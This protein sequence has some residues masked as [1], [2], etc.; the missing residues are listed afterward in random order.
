MRNAGSISYPTDL[1]KNRL[2]R[3]GCNGAAT[4][5]LEVQRALLEECRKSV[6]F[7]VNTFAWT[8]NVMHRADDPVV[9]FVTF[10][11]QDELLEEIEYCIEHKKHLVICK[12]RDVG[13]TWL[14]LALYFWR[15][16]FR[17]NQTFMVASRTEELVDGKQD[18][19]DT[20]FYRLEFFYEYTPF[21][22][23]PEG[24]LYRC[25]KGSLV[26]KRDRNVI[27][28]T[29]HSAELGRGGKRTSMM[30]DE[31]AAYTMRQG[32]RALDASQFGARSR[33][34]NST[35]EPGPNAFNTIMKRPAYRQ[36]R[37]WWTDWPEKAAGLYKT[38]VDGELVI[39]D[40]K[41][42]FPADYPFVLDGRL[43]SPYFDEQAALAS[44]LEAI[45]KELGGDVSTSSHLIFPVALLDTAERACIEAPVHVGNLEFED[46]DT[47]E[48]KKWDKREDGIVRLWLPLENGRILTADRN[49][50]MGADISAGTGASDSVLII[51]DLDTGEQVAS[52][53]TNKLMPEDFAKLTIAVWRWFSQP[54]KSKPM[55]IWEKMGPGAQ[56]GRWIDRLGCHR[57]YRDEA[58]GYTLARGP[59]IAGF[60][61]TRDSKAQILGDLME[62]MQQRT[63]VP[64]ELKLI[65]EMRCYVRTDDGG[66]EYSPA[67]AWAHTTGARRNHGDRVIGAALANRLSTARRAVDKNPVERYPRGTMAWL[68][69]IEKS[70]QSNFLNGY[71]PRKE[72]VYA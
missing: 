65:D 23:R 19:T 8:N 55:L 3:V 20:L 33:I 38:G 41:Y 21:W 18:D 40:T 53:V 44:S 27:N 2:Y 56:F 71:G 48:P 50:G 47:C 42:K 31:F 9:P 16:L 61:T 64:R 26:N 52:V 57:V 35:P 22:M 39:L 11:K 28:G 17:R 5:D 34:F 59:G 29:A 13:A 63:F 69:M 70:K 49:F 7:W 37:I 25:T 72:L 32:W 43:R 68:D 66:C 51:V 10:A 1:D 36:F 67:L 4:G 24:S 62:A 6:L 30:V 60:M 45:D 15:W 12:S 46:D 54:D 58:S 14:V